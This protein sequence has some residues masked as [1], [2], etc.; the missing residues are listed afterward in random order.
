MRYDVAVIGGGPAGLM[1][2]RTAAGQ[3]LKTILFEKKKRVAPVTRACCE[4][5]I[6]D[7]DFQGDTVRLRDGKI[8]ALVAIFASKVLDFHGEIPTKKKDQA[9]VREWV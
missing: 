8:V 3:G 4:Q 7:E 1:A 2:A 6:M 9:A 5:L